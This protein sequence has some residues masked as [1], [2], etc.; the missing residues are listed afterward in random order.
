MRWCAWKRA[1]AHQRPAGG[2]Q[3]PGAP[4]GRTARRRWKQSWKEKDRNWSSGGSGAG[5]ACFLEASPIDVSS[6]LREKLF[7]KVDTVILTSATLAVGGT[8]DF[9]KR[10][11]GID[12]CTERVF[13]SHFDFKSQAMLYTPLHLPEPREA[14]FGRRAA[15]EVVEVLKATP[16]AGRLC[17]SPRYQQMRDIFERVR[18]RVRFPCSFRAGAAYCSAGALPLHPARRAVC[19]EFVLA[20]RGRSGRATERRDY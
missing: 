18:P 7:E 13:P 8:F 1:E 10:R 2:D 17:S 4:R 19:H 6:I 16:R 11:L 12:H 3:Q 20:G 14:D 9:L 15:D 5:A